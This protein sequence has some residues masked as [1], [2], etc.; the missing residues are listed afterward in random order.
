MSTSDP[1]DVKTPC[2]WWSAELVRAAIE[3]GYTRA[4]MAAAWGCST[5]A[6]K[7]TIDREG[8]DA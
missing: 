4:E 3:Q 7:R 6:I 8:I 2:P 1:L 5:D